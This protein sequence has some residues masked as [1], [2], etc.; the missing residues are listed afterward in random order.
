[1]SDLEQGLCTECQLN[2]KRTRL[3]SPCLC[4]SLLWK[5]APKRQKL[6]NTSCLRY[7][8]N[9]SNQSID[10]LI[11]VRRPKGIPNVINHNKKNTCII[12]GLKC[13]NVWICMDVRLQ[14]GYTGEKHATSSPREMNGDA[15]PCAYLRPTHA[16]NKNTTRLFVKRGFCPRRALVGIHTF[17]RRCG[18]LH[19]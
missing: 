3:V 14:H 18:I 7:C 10:R 15:T 8:Q 2:N 11:S 16:L 19:T 6:K 9:N 1:M 12:V 17:Y 5:Q 4:L 13:M